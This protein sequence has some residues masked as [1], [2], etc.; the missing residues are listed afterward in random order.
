[1]IKIKVKEQNFQKGGFSS[2]TIFGFD[3]WLIW[4]RFSHGCSIPKM[5][6]TSFYC[7]I[8][9]KGPIHPNITPRTENF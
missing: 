1:M 3:L 8:I 4:S 2:T 6:P 9:L 7:S 5:V